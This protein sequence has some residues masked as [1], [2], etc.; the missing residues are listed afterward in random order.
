MGCVGALSALVP[1][2]YERRSAIVQAISARVSGARAATSAADAV[3]SSR[4]SITAPIART[5]AA[6][7]VMNAATP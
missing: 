6:W 4:P 1:P 3:G 2:A 7:R 5:A